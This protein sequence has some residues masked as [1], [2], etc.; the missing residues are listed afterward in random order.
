[1]KLRG[2]LLVADGQGQGVGRNREAQESQGQVFPSPPLPA[3]KS[4]LWEWQG[5]RLQVPTISL[6]TDLDAHLGLWQGRGLPQVSLRDVSAGAL[7]W[8][9]IFK[10]LESPIAC[11]NDFQVAIMF[12]T[13]GNWLY[14]LLMDY[15]P[16][17][18][19]GGGQDNTSQL[20]SL[21]LHCPAAI[22]QAGS[23]LGDDRVAVWAHYSSFMAPGT[24]MG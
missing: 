5:S 11:S 18:N 3:G 4:E 20:C 17:K 15:P 14:Q 19:V 9:Q 22:S 2:T 16:K 1:M 10:N 13:Q 12:P 23:P 21:G 8:P 7:T 24:P 6:L